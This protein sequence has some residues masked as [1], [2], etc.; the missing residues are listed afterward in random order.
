[1]SL[2]WNRCDITTAFHTALFCWWIR[3]IS[4]RKNQSEH[5]CSS[6]GGRVLRRSVVLLRPDPVSQTTVVPVKRLGLGK[7]LAVVIMIAGLLWGK[8][9][10]HRVEIWFWRPD[11]SKSLASSLAPN[12][13]PYRCQVA[14]GWVGGLTEGMCSSSYSRSICYL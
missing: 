6:A 12:G 7:A 1:M 5:E 10:S 2:V 9:K 11:R 4:F 3:D 14:G 13:G 8:A